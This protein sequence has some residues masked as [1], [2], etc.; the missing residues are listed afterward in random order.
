MILIT[1]ATGLLGSYIARLL[2]SRG[3]QVRGLRRSSSDLSLLGDAVKQIEWVEGDVTDV[4]SL[5]EAM[6]GVSRIYH[7]AALI[8]MQ[9]SHLDSMLKTN[10]EGTANVVNAALDAGIDK[11]LYVSSIAAFGRPQ[12]EGVLIDENLDVK[13]STDNFSYYRS[14]LYAEREVWRGIAEG[15]PAAIICP[16]TILGGGFWNV[17]P[18][19]IFAQ[20]YKGVPFYTTGTNAFVDVRDVAAIA[21]LLMDSDIVSEKYIVSA[22]NCTFHELMNLTADALQK[23]RPAIAI[24]K[25]LAAIAWRY[26]SVKA[27]ITKSTPLLTAESAV[28]AQSDFRYSNEKICQT[29]S[30][31]FRPLSETITDVAKLYL[32]SLK[33]KKGYGIIN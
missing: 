13:D 8:S 18:N 7:C 14:K 17:T 5:D 12:P 6:Q 1:G 4:L 15:L 25:Y 19:N 33:E 21:L 29:L 16:S 3:E 28:M 22:E 9:P 24:H 31:Q 30:Y 32:Q 20:V 23:K 10:T 11:L 2:V 26:E 27:V